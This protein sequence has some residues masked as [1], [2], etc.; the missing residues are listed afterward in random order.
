V[1]KNVYVLLSGAPEI[2]TSL[3]A[4]KEKRP[5]A[6]GQAARKPEVD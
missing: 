3:A 4:G 5:D 2:A 1:Y 6:D